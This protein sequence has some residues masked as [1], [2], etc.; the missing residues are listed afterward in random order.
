M[1]ADFFRLKCQGKNITTGIPIAES[2]YKS[3]IVASG[4]EKISEESSK[5]LIMAKQAAT[6]P[7]KKGITFLRLSSCQKWDSLFDI[8]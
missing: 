7:I 4:T 8:G 1:V 3:L 6:Y 5:K 2:K